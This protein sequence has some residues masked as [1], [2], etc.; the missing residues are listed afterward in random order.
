MGV[1]CEKLSSIKMWFILICL[2]RLEVCTHL[3]RV[4]AGF[5]QIYE[6]W[7]WSATGDDLWL[8]PAKGDSWEHFEG[9]ITEG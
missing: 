6:L 8:Y 7:N 4:W 2:H 9:S 3:C 5:C 1:S